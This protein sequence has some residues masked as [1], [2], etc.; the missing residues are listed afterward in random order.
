MRTVGL[1]D[2]VYLSASLSSYENQNRTDSFLKIGAFQFLK[3]SRKIWKRAWKQVQFSNP[4]TTRKFYTKQAITY[5]SRAALSLKL[6]QAS[7]HELAGTIL[8]YKCA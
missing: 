3:H 5:I 8:G 1:F 7:R 4:K 2:D 6:L